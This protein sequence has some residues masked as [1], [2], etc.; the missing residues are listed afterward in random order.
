[1]NDDWR[2]QV[3]LHDD[4]HPQQLVESLEARELEHDLSDA[5]HDKVIVSRNDATIF[6]YAGSREQTE[7]A[8]RLIASLDERHGWDADMEL[9]RWHPIA[10]DWKDPDEPLP[11]SEAARKA[12]REK[13]MADERRETENG[14]PEFEV[15]VD[16][17]SRHE[18]VRLVEA[19]R[20]EDLSTVRRW[21]Y[22]LV[23]A[24]DE[25]N[26]K[27]IAERIRGEVSPDARVKVEGTW[28]AA[29][30]ERQPNPFAVFGGLGG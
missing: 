7:S 15:R 24:T 5:F 20:N 19:L 6:L 8:R 3:D 28:G 26:A 4:D 2:L 17:P 18:A 22:V 10:E 23:G 27:A 12:E 9:R 29:Y 11:E 1:M 30:A 16:L 13:L 14:H 25:D 21:R